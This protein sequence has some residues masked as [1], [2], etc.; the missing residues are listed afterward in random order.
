MK[1]YIEIYQGG[2]TEENLIF[3]DN[4]LIVDGAAHHVIDILTTPPIPTSLTVAH[5]SSISDFGI[6][7]ITLGSAQGSLGYTSYQPDS[8]TSKGLIRVYAP[9]SGQEV[10]LTDATGHIRRF[11]FT[12]VP[13]TSTGDTFGSAAVNGGDT[14]RGTYVNIYG[15]TYTNERAEQL[16]L[17]IN[18]SSSA[19]LKI[20]AHQAGTSYGYPF[21]LGQ[22]PTNHPEYEEGSTGG[23]HI[24]RNVVLIQDIGG[25]AGNTDMTVASTTV[26]VEQPSDFS[27]YNFGENGLRAGSAIK[28]K[29]TP[30]LS[31]P[32]NPIDT[33]IQPSV[34]K[35]PGRLGHFLNYYNFSGSYPFLD[36]VD[37]REYGCYLPSGGISF[38]GSSFGYTHP[39]NLTNDMSGTQTGDL[40]SASAINSEGFILESTVARASQTLVDASGGFIVSGIADVSATREVK[41]ILTISYKD[42]K[43]LDY[44][45]GGIGAIGLWTIDMDATLDK[46]SSE[47]ETTGIDLYNVADISR[48]P[49]FKLF[50]KKVFLPGGLKIDETSSNDDYMTITWGLKF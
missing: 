50:A 8:I 26:D 43:F 34:G 1:G 27:I 22:L 2:I 42:W 38:A 14:G 40:N 36:T 12:T 30:L 19:D 29:S 25:V 6:Q 17:A 13:S 16:A 7:A 4:N 39:G 44:Y 33:D 10:R 46:Y 49:V 18:H 28:V 20:T 15:L 21:T 47:S 48:N 41:Y 5:T 9:H 32:P 35:G 23:T 45:Y 3:S 11:M 24:T 31:I 37:L